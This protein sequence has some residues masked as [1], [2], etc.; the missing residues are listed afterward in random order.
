VLGS[1]LGTVYDPAK[2][3]L[4]ADC[5]EGS[6]LVANAHTVQPLTGGQSSWASNA[7]LGPVADAQY[8]RWATLGGADSAWITP[9]ALPTATSTATPT[10][11][12]KYIPVKTT[13]AP[14]SGGGPNPTDTPAATQAVDTPVPQDTPVPPTTEAPP[15]DTVVPATSMPETP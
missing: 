14:Q 3:I 4:E 12:R 11:T 15:A 10:V 1:I 13:E 6:C 2:A 9:T 7:A 5:L 8:D